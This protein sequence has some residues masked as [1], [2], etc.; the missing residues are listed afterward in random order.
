MFKTL[1]TAGVILVAALTPVH[2]QSE[3][4]YPTE[5]VHF[6]VQSA[7]GS[8]LDQTI[9]AVVST[10]EREKLVNVGLPITNM[11]STAVGAQTIVNKHVADPYLVSL[12]SISGMVRFATGTTPYSHKDWTPIARLTSDYYSILVRKDSP[13]Q[14]IDE[15]VSALKADPKAFPIVGANTDDRIFYGL[16]FKRVGIDPTQVNY[17]PMSGGGEAMALLLEGSPGAMIGSV[18]DASAM[19][20]S[21]DVRALAVSSAQRL[22]G[23]MADA[24]T[25]KEKGIDFDWQNF[26]YIMGGPDM[27]DYAV[28]YWQA[29]LQ[30]MIGTE[31]WKGNLEKFGWGQAYM[32]EGL[33]P[34][35]DNA[36][37][38]ISAAAK[39]LG[40]V[41]Q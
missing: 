12:N 38:Q 30:K 11:P 40:M 34:F 28:K 10:L 25:L 13:I 16:L 1:L 37:D 33:V 23:A 29:L 35:L 6:I 18:S 2:A 5:P 3:A 26:R 41:K 14:T 31:T 15:F 36:Q 17:I 39:E 7:A 22:P 19:V 20:G 32:T 4:D 24:P 8:S 9:R 21:G 27:P